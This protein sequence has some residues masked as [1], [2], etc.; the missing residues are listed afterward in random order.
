MNDA[1]R[2]QNDTEKLV[3]AWLNKYGVTVESVFIPWSQSRAKDDKVPVWGSE[4]LRYSK[5]PQYSLQ[6]RVT[7]K[8]NG[9]E[10]LTTE[11]GAGVA[12]CPAYMQSPPKNGE[13]RQAYDARIEAEIEQGFVTVKRSTVFGAGVS[14]KMILDPAYAGTTEQQYRPKV[15][16]PITPKTTDVLA[17][18]AMDSGVMDAGG[19]EAWAPELGY[20]PDSRAAEAIYRACLDTALK[21]RSALG[22]AG[23]EELRTATQDW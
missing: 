17:S 14:F 22:D 8:R 3:S 11:Y 10:F 6:W 1:A 19:F 23:I 16:A 13:E 20:D 15:R 4:P 18:L 5:Q 9:R 7:L 2:K 21:M 12:H